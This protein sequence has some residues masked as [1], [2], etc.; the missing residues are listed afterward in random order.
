MQLIMGQESIEYTLKIS[1]RSRYIRLA[2]F[3]GGE[4]VATVP[5]NYSQTRLERFIFTKRAWILDK[6]KK[7]RKYQV[8]SPQKY[9]RKDY[10]KYKEEARKFVTTKLDYFNT[11]Y[12]YRWGRVAIKDHKTL[13]GSCSRKNNLNFNY[14][15]LFLPEKQAD[16][17]IVHELCHLRE[18]NHSQNFWNLVARVFPDHKKIRRELRKMHI[19]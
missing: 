16:Y 4:L 13:W 7:M 11:F 18:H 19:G 1:S 2:I 6:Q 9:T 3:P 8:L 5:K 17:I 12:N 14:K 10:L 15:I